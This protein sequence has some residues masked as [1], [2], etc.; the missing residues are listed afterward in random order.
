MLHSIIDND[1]IELLGP[2]Q[3]QIVTLL[4]EKRDLS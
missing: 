3:Y 1:M 4:I 2:L